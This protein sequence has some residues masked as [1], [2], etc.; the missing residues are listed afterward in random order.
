MN[1]HGVVGPLVAAINPWT[2]A[3][4][5]VSTGY[6]TGAD[7]ARTPT[8]AAPVTVQAQ[9]QS[10]TPRDLKQLDSLNIQGVTRAAYVTGDFEGVD[11]ARNKGGDLLTFG[12]ETWLV[13]AVIEAW[14][15]SAGW[16][17]VGLMKQVG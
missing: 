11:R 2:I 10:L 8:Y 4:W 13:A 15:P 6:M 14:T 5:S 17:K 7:G 3:Q 1:L 9:V 12:G 16:S